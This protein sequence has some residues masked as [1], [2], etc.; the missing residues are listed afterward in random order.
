MFAPAK[1]TL[2]IMKT[3]L[4]SSLALIFG[5]ALSAQDSS[6]KTDA[7][8]EVPT[9]LEEETE[10]PFPVYIDITKYE[11]HH[12]VGTG[13]REKFWIDV[14]GFGIYVDKAAATPIMKA[15]FDKASKVDDDDEAIV[16]ID[17][18]LLDNRFNK[19]MRWVM[20]RDVEG[21][22]IADAFDDSLGPEINKMYAKDEKAL[23]TS[24]KQM[25]QLRSWFEETDLLET[26]ELLFIWKRNKLDSIVN[27]KSL[28]VID[29][30]GVCYA[31]F[32]LFLNEDDPID[33]DAYE[34]TIAALKLMAYPKPAVQEG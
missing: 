3:L 24:L 6:Q 12:L 16:I 29:N 28:G 10:I 27:G 14:Y 34:A 22:D 30:Y 26:D 4:L 13:V 11:R 32:K 31:M 33:D 2:H 5:A 1:H 23:A 15:A 25:A 17:A 7:Q 20:A 18:A 8:Q 21:V 9:V 19:T